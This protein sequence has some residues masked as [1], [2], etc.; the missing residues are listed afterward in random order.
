[1]GL[2]AAG[3]GSRAKPARITAI[4]LLAVTV[5]KGFLF[6]LGSLSGLYRVGSFVGLAFCLALVAVALQRFVL[7]DGEGRT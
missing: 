5:L 4:A 7:R 1:V 2:L 6:D 3:I